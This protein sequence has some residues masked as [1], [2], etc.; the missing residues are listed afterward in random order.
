MGRAAGELVVGV[1]GASDVVAKVLE[2]GAHVAEELGTGVD[3]RLTAVAYDDEHDVA[4]ELARAPSDLDVHLFAGP[5]P[6]D[7]AREAGAITL[8]STFIPVSGAPLY[9]ALLRAALA[10]TDVRRLSVDS[11]GR[12]ELEEAYAD[13][14]LPAD[15]AHV[16]TYT[17]PAAAEE[18]AT[19]HAELHRAGRT[20]AALTHVRSVAQRLE[21]DEVPVLLSRPTAATIRGTIRT[22]VLLGHGSRLEE[23]RIAIGIV[24]APQSGTSG[25]G[26]I[27]TAL[28]GLLL[29]EAHR[30]GATVLPRDETSYYL[31]ATLGSLVAATDDFAEPPFV[32]RVRAEL[33][34]T[35]ELGIGLGDTARDAEANARTALAQARPSDEDSAGYLVGHDGHVLLLPSAARARRVVQ[36]EARTKAIATLTRLA[37]ALR[38]AG[39]LPSTEPVVVDAPLVARLLDVTPRAAR[40]LLTSLAELNLAWQMPP[41]RT[42]GRG[43][44]RQ[45]YRLML[46]KL[47]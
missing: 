16:R 26:G 5:L 15:E 35:V 32:E 38:E 20:S 46:E 43:R 36:D 39:T 14:G 21:D 8:P 11:V 31:I 10:G 12:R 13:V 18:F 44:P 37:E 34:I 45:S 41:A 22:A 33:G 9:G 17:D 25:F 2:V 3:F 42:P 40:R 4:R 6:Y 24:Q 29:D 23:S 30:M 1:V 47:E 19:F 7:L 27:R 28:H